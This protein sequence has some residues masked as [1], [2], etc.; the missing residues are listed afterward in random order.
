MIG[1]AAQ[2]MRGVAWT[3]LFFVSLYS[4][5]RLILGERPPTGWRRAA[6]LQEL[7]K[8]SVQAVV[9]SYLPA[10]ARWPP[11]AILFRSD[12]RPGFWLGTRTREGN[13]PDLWIGDGLGPVPAELGKL[14]GCLDPGSSAACPEGWVHLSRAGPNGSSLHLLTADAAEAAR[15]LE[16]LRP[17]ER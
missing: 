17:S 12:P 6:E 9:P 10:G 2:L 11:E 16:G 14:A 7:S 1:R 3:G 4:I 15:I 13:G 8:H 5:D